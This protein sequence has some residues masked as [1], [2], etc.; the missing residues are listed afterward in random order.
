MSV[1]Y[2]IVLLNEDILENYHYKEFHHNDLLN[3]CLNFENIS[4]FLSLYQNTSLPLF[5]FPSGNTCLLM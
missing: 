3:I 4:L 1:E 2:L 5:Q